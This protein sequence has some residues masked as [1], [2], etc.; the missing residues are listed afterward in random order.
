MP[1]VELAVDEREEIRAPIDRGNSL[2]AARR[3][4]G[5]SVSAV[6]RRLAHNSGHGRNQ[7]AAAEHRTEP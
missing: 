2:T 6:Y 3:L 1:G 7:A 5:R 4:R